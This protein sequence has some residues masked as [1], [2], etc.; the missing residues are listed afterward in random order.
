MSRS[1]GIWVTMRNCLPSTVTD[2]FSFCPKIKVKYLKAYVF[3]FCFHKG[4]CRK[5][6]LAQIKLDEAIMGCSHT[7]ALSFYVTKTVM[8]GP[9]W[10]WSDQIDSDLTIMAWSRPK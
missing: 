9:R 1:I 10:F 2:F 7:N 6:I 5:K 4:E 3:V 8:V